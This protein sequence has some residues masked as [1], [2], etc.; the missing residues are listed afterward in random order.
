VPAVTENGK[1]IVHRA[2]SKTKLLEER[3]NSHSKL[4]TD[5]IAIMIQYNEK[6]APVRRRKKELILH[7]SS[8]ENPIKLMVE[9]FLI[10]ADCRH[11]S[12]TYEHSKD[13]ACF[14]GCH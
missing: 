5:V 14:C 9:S 8:G 1:F 13:G 10:C 12:I 6:I 7:K 2:A 4:K 11:N 3:L